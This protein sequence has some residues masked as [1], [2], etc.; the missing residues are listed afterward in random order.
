[1]AEK[2]NLPLH[3]LEFD[4][5]P[6]PSTH[7]TWLAFY[8]VGAGWQ[9]GMRNAFCWRARAMLEKLPAVL[10]ELKIDGLIGDQ[11]V[12]AAGRR[13]APASPS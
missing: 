6:W 9:I 13:P 1:M 10:Q 11:I 5:V 12:S 8:L 4:D 3:P 2:L 7:L